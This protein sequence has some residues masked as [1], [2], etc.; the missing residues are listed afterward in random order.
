LGAG[1][2]EIESQLKWDR[3][4]A[5]NK[6]KM[7]LLGAGKTGEVASVLNDIVSSMSCLIALTA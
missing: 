5:K 6:I 7:L 4:M 1:N 2:D 3:M